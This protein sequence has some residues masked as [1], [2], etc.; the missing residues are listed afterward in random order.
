MAMSN[1]SL[2]CHRSLW[3]QK[4]R[5][6]HGIRCSSFQN[7]STEEEDTS[8]PEEERNEQMSSHPKDSTKIGLEKYVNSGFSVPKRF[9]YLCIGPSFAI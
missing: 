7:N 2:K 5:C 1:Q 6:D 9:M 3:N 8:P 4:T